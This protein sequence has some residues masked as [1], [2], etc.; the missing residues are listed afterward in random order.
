MDNAT[1]VKEKL[2]LL[3]ENLN[4]Q[5]QN[6]PT[7]LRDILKLL[8]ADSEVTTLL[9]EEEC[10]IFVRGLKAQTS[11]EITVATKKS[12]KKSTKSLGVM[13]L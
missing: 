7:A 8:K 2:A 11:T 12:T 10:A 4:G 6:L 5:V 13:D 1:Q 9:S 3:E